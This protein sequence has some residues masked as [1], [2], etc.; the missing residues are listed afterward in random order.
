MTMKVD[1]LAVDRI[2]ELEAL[3]EAEREKS[4]M[5]HMEYLALRQVLCLMQADREYS[6]PVSLP[7]PPA[8]H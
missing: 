5:L 6:E 7:S 4:N 3:L 2:K 8:Y 1:K